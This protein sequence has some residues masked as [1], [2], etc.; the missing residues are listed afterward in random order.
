[1]SG[2]SS[3]PFGPV[4]L[5]V[6]EFDRTEFD[7]EIMPEFKRLKDAGIVRLVDV[8]FVAKRNGEV[9]TIHASDLSSEEAES[10][11]ALVGALIGAELGEDE[12]ESTAAL[13]AAEGSDG[14]LLDAGDV[15]YLTDAIPEGTSAAVALIEHL[16]AIPLRDKLVAAG[17]SLLA[18]EWI[19][20]A[21]LAAAAAAGVA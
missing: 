11:G 21:D 10:F 7:G 2:G 1:M 5:L 13:G 17:A 4:Q 12:V 18:D 6:L 9:E 8:L 14:H 20:P 19:H 3:T 16:W 15:W